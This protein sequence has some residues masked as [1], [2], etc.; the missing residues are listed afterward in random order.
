[1]IDLGM[2]ESVH[3]REGDD[4][5][6]F[7]LW[8]ANTVSG[9]VY[10]GN[11]Y[12]VVIEPT[13]GGFRAFVPARSEWSVAA[14]AR[15]TVKEQLASLITES[16]RHEEELIAQYIEPDPRRSGEENARLKANGTSV[17]AII[18]YLEG[19]KGNIRQAA[20]DYDLPEPAIEAAKAYYLRHK[21]VIDAR[22]AANR[23]PTPHG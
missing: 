4:G 8:P 5:P 2:N 20:E 17:W 21:T 23:I 3:I 15:D 7:V 13:D 19:V 22:R 9:Q 1:M 14:S 18:G 16:L 12:P 6:Y 11:Y 10:S